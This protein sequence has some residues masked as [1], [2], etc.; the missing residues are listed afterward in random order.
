MPTTSDTGE[1]I[2][3]EAK[4]GD[5]WDTISYL[6]YGY[7]EMYA[8]LLIRANIRMC[9]VV[10]FEGGEKVKVPLIDTVKTPETL[11]PWRR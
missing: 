10:T 11:P 3:Y 1:Y 8:S 2:I 5:T 6:N 4:A 9:D 7:T